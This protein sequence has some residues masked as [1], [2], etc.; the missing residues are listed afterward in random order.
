[1]V[2][3]TR[4]TPSKQPV[5]PGRVPIALE[6]PL[7]S[8]EQKSKSVHRHPLADP[9]GP[10]QRPLAKLYRPS[11]ACNGLG[12]LGQFRHVLPALVATRDGGAPVVG[13]HHSNVS[14]SG[15]I[16]DYLWI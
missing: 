13:L 9:G 4:L 1:M 8:A 6:V 10:S 7:G 16:G 5:H 3:A 14:V 11:S 12:R 15:D 2:Q